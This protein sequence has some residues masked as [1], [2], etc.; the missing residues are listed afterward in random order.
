MLC[1]IVTL[2]AN[3]GSEGKVEKLLKQI[4]SKLV[5]TSEVCL[6]IIGQVE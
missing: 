2:H 3:A 4:L 6:K 1:A 5:I